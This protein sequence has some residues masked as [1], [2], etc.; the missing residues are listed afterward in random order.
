MLSTDF[1]LAQNTS[2]AVSAT[3]PSGT[4]DLVTALL[5]YGVNVS[6]YGSSSSGTANSRRNSASSGCSFSVS[7]GLRTLPCPWNADLGVSCQCST[8]SV[9]YPNSVSSQG[10]SSYN[11]LESGYWSNQQAEVDPYCVFLPSSSVQVAVALLLSRLT[12]CQFAVKSGGHAAF[13]GASNIQGGI[14]INL[15]KLDQIVLSSDK[16]IASV[17]PG[18]TWFDVYTDLEPENLTVIGG[19][20]AAIGVGGLTLGGKTPRSQLIQMITRELTSPSNRWNIIF[21]RKLWLGL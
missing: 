16:D 9:L 11:L 12:Q 6:D 3:S 2:S 20:V 13:A 7:T 17:G 18:N 21:L 19:R 10:S 4:F 15:A 14:T 8:L 1:T 5:A